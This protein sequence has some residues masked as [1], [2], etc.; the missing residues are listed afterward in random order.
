ML[1]AFAIE[2]VQRGDSPGLIVVM[3]VVVGVLAGLMQARLGLMGVGGLIKYIPYP[4]VSGYLTG[5]GLI[6][7]GS[8]VP[9]LLGAPADL[10]LVGGAARSSAGTGARWRSDASRR[11]VAIAAPRVQARVPGIILGILAGMLAYGAVRAR[12]PAL[13]QVAATAS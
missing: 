4:V 5:V 6:I 8:Q 13:R 2:M 10:A 3:L 7:I 1:S 11:L 12:D 9:K